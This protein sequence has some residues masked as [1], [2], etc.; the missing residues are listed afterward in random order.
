VRPCLCRGDY[1]GAITSDEELSGDA[2]TIT[3][4]DARGPKGATT[5]GKDH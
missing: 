4:S 5:E 1:K 2:M 3:V